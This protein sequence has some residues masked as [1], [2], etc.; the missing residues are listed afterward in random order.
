MIRP[1]KKRDSAN[2]AGQRSR[3]TGK[4]Y[5]NDKQPFQNPLN[6]VDAR[7]E[8]AEFLRSVEQHEA[9]S[10]DSQNAES[11]AAIE[12]DRCRLEDGTL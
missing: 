2:C 7:T 3:C 5:R 4:R 11:N 1:I 12:D 6:S 10:E 9:D 8:V